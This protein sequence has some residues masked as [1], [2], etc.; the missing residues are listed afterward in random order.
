VLG[1]RLGCA[2]A[3]GDSARGVAERPFGGVFW[4]LESVGLGPLGLQSLLL[5]ERLWANSACA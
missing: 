5:V 3:P 4:T 1:A 2:E